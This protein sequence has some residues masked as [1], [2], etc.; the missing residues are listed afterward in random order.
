[1]AKSDKKSKSIPIRLTESEW[2]LMKQ[3]ESNPSE[4]VR[5]LFLKDISKEIAVSLIY[6]GHTTSDT[7]DDIVNNFKKYY[8]H[9]FPHLVDNLKINRL[10]RNGKFR[11]RWT[12]KIQKKSLLEFEQLKDSHKLKYALD[13][14]RNPIIITND[15][16]ETKY[17]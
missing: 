12:G 9:L 1:M 3:L 14:K 8:N 7:T 11:I 17:N 4:Y 6:T 5:Q 13:I 2:K 16:I 10:Y 15:T